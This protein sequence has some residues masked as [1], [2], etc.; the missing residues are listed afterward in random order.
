[1]DKALKGEGGLPGPWY[2]EIMQFLRTGI[3]PEDLPV[4][5]KIQRQS[6]R[7]TLQDGVLYRRSFQGPLLKCVTR[8]EGLMA[9][10]EINGGIC[11]SHINGKA[12]TQKIIRSGIFWPSVAKDAQDHVWRCNSCQTDASIPYQPPHEMVCPI[13]LDYFT[14]RVEAK[15]LTW[16]DQEQVYQFLGDIF[17][18]FGVPQVQ[19]TNNET[20]FTV[21]KIEDLFLELDMEYRTASAS[22]PHA[23]GQIEVM[24][25]LIFKGV[26]KRLQEERGCWDQDLPTVLWWVASQIGPVGGKKGWRGGQNGQIQGKGSRLLQQKG[27]GQKIPAKR[28]NPHSTI[29]IRLWE[30][31]K[32]GVLPGKS[33]HRPG[34]RGTT[35]V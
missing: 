29:G 10:E 16:Q 7:Y 28:S 26:K 35:H 22:Y 31:R 34:S 18:Q 15:P 14:K 1:M 32:I 21:R 17:T 19:V 13:S 12:L 27:P 9:I 8:E 5:N 3:L 20:Q 4:A 33:I 30:T 6:L 23:N 24:N 2:Q 11:G 25:R